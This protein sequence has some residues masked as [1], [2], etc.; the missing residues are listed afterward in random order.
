MESFEIGR[1]RKRKSLGWLFAS[2]KESR[3][4]E[5]KP[6]SQLISRPRKKR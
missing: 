6:S 5:R 3:L 4:I 1:P 2:N